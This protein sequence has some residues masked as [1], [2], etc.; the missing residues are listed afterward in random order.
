MANNNVQTLKDFR[1]GAGGRLTRGDQKA[2]VEMAILFLEQ[3]YVHLPLKVA[4]HA[5]NPIGRLRILRNYLEDSGPDTIKQE[6]IFH[7]AMLDIF[8]SLRDLHTNYSLPEPFSNCTAFLPFEVKSCIKETQQTTD[9][10]IVK[11]Q[12]E[13]QFIV[14]DVY[15]PDLLK[16]LSPSNFEFHIPATFKPGVEI[17]YWNGL[18][19]QRAVDI[20]A[21]KIGGSNPAARFKFGLLNMTCRPMESYLP[22][23]EDWVVIGYRTEDGQDLEYRQEWLAYSRHRDVARDATLNMSDYSVTMGI[24]YTAD[25]IRKMKQIMFA[26]SHVIESQRILAKSLSE[27]SGSLIGYPCTCK[28]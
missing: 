10:E 25:L 14:T 4:M 26:S 22:P 5:V 20:N 18:P 12:R 6:L 1:S 15:P 8:T 27:K 7:E 2:I 19:M 17:T 9:R 13:M 23:D 16:K 11:L 3:A 24:N 28:M 21:N